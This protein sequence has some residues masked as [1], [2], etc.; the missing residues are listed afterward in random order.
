MKARMSAYPKSTLPKGSNGTLNG[1]SDQTI[2]LG[3]KTSGL[4]RP[5]SQKLRILSYN[6][7]TGITSSKYHHYV[8]HSW[9]H[10]LPCAERMG[11]LDTFAGLLA[12][13]DIVGL[14]EV[15]AG[16]LRSGFIN[17]TK[18]LAERAHF[19]YW[20]DQTNR[21]LGKLAQHS[22][23]V[24]SR[25]LPTAI[26]EH[27]LPGVIPGR[28]ALSMQLGDK[29][30]LFLLILHLALGRRARLRQLGYIAELISNYTNV[31]ILGDM[32]CRAESTEMGWLLRN[33]D[34]R[35]PMDGLH[36]FPSWRPLR[37]IDQIL[38][39]SSLQ[40]ESVRV[41]DHALSDHLPIAMEITLP[42][43]LILQKHIPRQARRARLHPPA[44]RV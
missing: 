17:Q 38:I 4:S 15:D 14:Q 16:S 20:H 10:V 9:K 37:N 12:E 7:Q 18:Y 41:L 24:L 19:P 1:S 2:D 43:D 21:N 30:G 40:V 31:V 34:L 8:T 13:Y 44:I 22:T 29:D 28:G 25:Y 39:S 33:S 36:T 27:K 11:N 23:G 32:N 42:D 26:A 6:I 3:N 35:A 5:E